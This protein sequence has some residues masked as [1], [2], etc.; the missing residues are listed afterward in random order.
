MTHSNADFLNKQEPM[1]R[2]CSRCG[3]RIPISS[4]YD[5]CRE[6]MKKELFPKVKDF[7]N[8]NEYVNEMILAEAMGI[9]KTIIHEWISE[10]HLEYRDNR[11]H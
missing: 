10:G 5:Q 4:P 2:H 1:T 6:C 7:I 3:C 8:E 9:D 11:L